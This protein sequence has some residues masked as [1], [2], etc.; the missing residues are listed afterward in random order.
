MNN[1]QVTKIL[2]WNIQSTNSITGSKFKDHQFT[3]IF[4]NYPIVCLQEIRQ[5]LKFSGY[6]CF[7]NTRKNNKS[8]GVCTLIRNE[9]ING[10]QRVSCSITD[11]VVCKLSHM[12]FNIPSD[13]FKISYQNSIL[14][15]MNPIHDCKIF[16]RMQ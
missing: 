12:F 4:E 16:V 8:G 15:R 2:S 14:K 7:N 3:N 13:I 11:V 1:K 6:R 5:P 10:V 9:L